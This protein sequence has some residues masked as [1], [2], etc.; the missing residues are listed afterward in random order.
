MV[1]ELETVALFCHKLAYQTEDQSPILRDDLIMGDY[2]RDIFEL[3]IARGDVDA[4]QQKIS[5][6]LRLALE[7]MGGPDTPLARSE[8]VS[9]PCDLFAHDLHLG[10]NPLMPRH[11]CPSLM[12]QMLTLIAPC[13]AHRDILRSYVGCGR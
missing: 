8:T 4:I 9:I 6:C 3:L 7:A 13:E 12:R 10:S 1:S 2:Q 11:Y 5:E